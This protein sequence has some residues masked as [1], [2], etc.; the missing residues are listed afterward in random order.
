MQY[1]SFDALAWMLMAYFVIR[2]LRTEDPRWWI[3][4]GASIG[5]GLM[6]KYSIVFLVAGLL[7]GMVLTDARR[8][9]RS[10]WFWYGVA[11]A[12]LIFLPNII[13]QAQH[14]FISLDFLKHIHARDIRIG[15]TKNFLPEQLN[16]T[17]LGLP[18]VLA[19]LYFYLIAPA[20]KRFR[21][22][23]WMYI[24][25]LVLFTIAKGRSYYLAAAY[26]M[27]YAGGSVRGEQW[28]ASMKRGWAN[29]VRVLGWTALL[30][31]I[32]LVSAIALPLGAVNSNWWKFASK[33]NGDFVEEIGWPE[34][35]QTVAQ[36]R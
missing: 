35:V 28:L 18:L 8:Y 22:V 19:G 32:A 27:L 17:L 9:F 12:L 31:D 34:L 25:P 6:S 15:R 7:A 5:F 24:V 3:A 21:T 36:I 20:G 11:T 33:I 1:V 4:I 2:L 10:R 29:T 23:G 26:P 13:W 14:A 16:L 30:A